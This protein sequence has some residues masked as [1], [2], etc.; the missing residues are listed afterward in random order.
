[1]NPSNFATFLPLATSKFVNVMQTSK[2]MIN[3]KIKQWRN[4]DA[5]IIIISEFGSSFRNKF[6]FTP[7]PPSAASPL[8]ANSIYNARHL[9]VFSD[10][11]F[12]PERVAATAKFRLTGSLYKGL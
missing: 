9:L 7:A 8:G 11:V 1:M 4:S 3:V 10:S 2:L 12:L 6:H 5:F